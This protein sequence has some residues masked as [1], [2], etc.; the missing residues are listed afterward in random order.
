MFAIS[1]HTVNICFAL[2]KIF[3]TF[4]AG[5]SGCLTNHFN[6]ANFKVMSGNWTSEGN[7]SDTNYD[8]SGDDYQYSDHYDGK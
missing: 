3:F 2:M 8:Y 5:V 7:A 4:K 6:W 1:I